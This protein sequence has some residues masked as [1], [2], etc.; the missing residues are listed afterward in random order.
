[1]PTILF[2]PLRIAVTA[3]CHRIASIPNYT[4]GSGGERQ[5]YGEVPEHEDVLT[6]L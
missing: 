4:L 3:V 2:T 6:D 5:R 1:M